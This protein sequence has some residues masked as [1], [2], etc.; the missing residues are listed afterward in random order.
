MG[1]YKSL[2]YVLVMLFYLLSNCDL[3]AQ[4]YSDP[5]VEYSRIRSI[6]FEGRYKE[7]AEAARK[8]LVEYPDYGDVQVLLGRILAWDGRYNEAAS[9]LDTL[10]A[11]KP[12]NRDAQDARMDVALWSGDYDLAERYALVILRENP[13]DTLT[14]EKIVKALLSD[15]KREE[16]MAHSDTLLKYAPS[17]AFAIALR[18][19]LH[20]EKSQDNIRVSYSFA[21]FTVP[22]K[23]LWQQLSVGGS[24]RFRWGTAGAGINAGHILIDADAIVTAT[25]FQAEFEAAPKLSERNYAYLTYAFSPGKYY[26]A[27]RASAEIW[28]I[29]PAG[30][31][32]SA[33]LCYYH[34]DRNIFIADLSL[35]K[36]IQ[37]YWLSAKTYFYFKDIGVTTSLYLT[38]RRYSNDIDYLQISLGAGTAPDEPFD[39][40]A[41]LERLSAYSARVTWNKSLNQRFIMRLNAGYSYEEYAANDY[42]HR[43]DGSVGIFYL[44][45]NLR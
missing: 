25:E 4:D 35:E 10:L 19:P 30:W 36:Y 8:L 26:P 23:R 41:D 31:A 22:Y 21:N 20:N 42:R 28:E 44:L 38:M 29:L 34:F 24:H 6:A 12:Q 32:F 5:E 13:A 39:I 11:L 40:Q 1:R 7:A 16:A 3:Y 15:G 18:E 27:H 33:G 45:K 9:V 14:R 17:N 43:I 37:R 2:P